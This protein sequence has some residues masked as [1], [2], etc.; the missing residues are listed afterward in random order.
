[1]KHKSVLGFV[2]FGSAAAI[3]AACSGASSSDVNQPGSSGTSG[4]D[5]SMMSS[6]DSSTQGP[7][8]GSTNPMNDGSTTN[9]DGSMAA[10]TLTS[11]VIVEGG[12]FPAANTCNGANTSPPLA[13]TGAPAATKSFAVILHDV[14]IDFLHASVYDIPKGV[15]SLPAN[16]QAAYAPSAPAGAHETKNF[17]GVFGYAGPCPPSEHVYEF[18]LY[19]LDVTSLPG[20]TMNTTLADA[21][22]TIKAHAIA[23]T[24]LTAKYKQ[25]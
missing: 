11:S 20:T 16:I 8:D 12:T 23:S 25:P 15:T 4:N 10:F 22:T 6:G 9:P 7:G 14:T 18:V 21:Q 19:A 13:W 24:K 2:L 17:N 3:V 5:A 1:M